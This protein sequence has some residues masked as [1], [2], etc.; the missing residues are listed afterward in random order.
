MKFWIDDEVLGR[1]LRPGQHVWTGI[2]TT[3][4]EI[5]SIHP[6]TNADFVGLNFTT[7]RGMYAHVDEPYRIRRPVEVE[8]RDVVDELSDIERGLR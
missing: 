6:D 2:S 4:H 7:K 8:V 3:W 1:D 5:A